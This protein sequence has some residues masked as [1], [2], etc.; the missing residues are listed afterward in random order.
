MKSLRVLNQKTG[1][2]RQHNLRHGNEN[3][4]KTNRRATTRRNTPHV[5][6]YPCSNL[7][8]SGQRHVG[9][10]AFG[11]RLFRPN[12]FGAGCCGSGCFGS[13]FGLG[14]F[15][16]SRFGSWLLR[17]RLFRSG[18][19]GIAGGLHMGPRLKKR[20]GADVL[21][22]G[23]RSFATQ[24]AISEVCRAMETNGI[25]MVYGR[26][27]QS[28]AMKRFDV[29]CLQRDADC[30]MPWPDDALLR[31]AVRWFRESPR[32]HGGAARK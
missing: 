25:P 21:R 24:S 5:I 31:G 12:C 10:N 7:C 3:I 18:C 13:C 2:H 29:C 32:R 11:L 22:L 27:A 20:K 28:R 1:K 26:K 9:V 4:C 17:L 6:C 14:C 23:R 16:S 19:F 8:S 30:A 15:G